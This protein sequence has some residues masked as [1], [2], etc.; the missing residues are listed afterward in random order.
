MAAEDYFWPYGQD[1]GDMYD[2]DDKHNIKEQQMSWKQPTPEQTYVKVL[3][4]GKSGGGKTRAAGTI[5]RDPNNVN[6]LVINTEGG[7]WQ[8]IK[9]Q[10]GYTPYVAQINNYSDLL[11]TINNLETNPDKIE[12]TIVDSVTELAILI[13]D[14]IVKGKQPRIQD[15]GTLAKR[16]Q[17]VLRRL[18]DLPMNV[19]FTALSSEVSYKD[20][21][22]GEEPDIIGS[23]K[24]ILP[25]LVD[26]VFYVGG[27][28]DEK[29]KTAYMAQTKP[30]KGRIAKMRGADLPAVVPTDNLWQLIGESFGLAGYE[31][32][33]TK[34]ESE[35]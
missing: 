32:I 10:L 26:A 23:T 20:E 31:K 7:G 12:N 8:T 9:Q 18:R 6:T 1:M 16:L 2:P 14:D 24:K 11:Q 29:G 27:F 28:D 19:V 15:F 30:A 3:L 17:T 33:E 25:A 4:Y 13:L 21:V 35:Q 34:T 22:V 5:N